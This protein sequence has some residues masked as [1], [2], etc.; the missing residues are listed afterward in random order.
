MSKK[1]LTRKRCQ[2]KNRSKQAVWT[3]EEDEKLIDSQKDIAGRHNWKFIG[4][5]LCRSPQQCLSRFERL[6]TA[7]KGPFDEEE[8]QFILVNRSKLSLVEIANQLGRTS[9]QVRDRFEN[10]LNP[11]LNKEEYMLEEDL[12][13]VILA[14]I[15]QNRWTLIATLMANNRS[16]HDLKNR[17]YTHIK[18][19]LNSSQDQSFK[20]FIEDLENNIMLSYEKVENFLQESKFLPLVKKYKGFFARP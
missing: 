4:K 5:L 2:N 20:S 3:Q 15:K 19:K 1:K 10:V 7:K 17:Y 18:R 11:A 8:D 16:G 9:K 14:K 12:V 13:L 6:M